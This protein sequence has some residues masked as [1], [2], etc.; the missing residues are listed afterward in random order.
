MMDWTTRDMLTATGGRLLCGAL[1]TTFS[2]IGIDSRQLDLDAFF[3]A[4][5]G[6]IHDGHKFAPD[7]VARGGRGVLVREGRVAKTA[8]ATWKKGGV[9]CIAV[10]DTTRALGDLAAYHR[11]R[12]PAR[13]AAL[14]GS[15]GKTTTRAMTAAIFNRKAATLATRGNLNNEIGLPLTLLQLKA[16]HAL[17]VVEMGM[18]HPGEIDRMGRMAVPDIGMIINVAPAH[19]E[20]LQTIEGVRRAKGE[21]LNHIQPDGRA[22]INADDEQCR[23]LI[24]TCPVETVLFGFGP[25]ARVRGRELVSGRRG[26]TFVLQLPSGDI[27]VKLQVPGK[28]MVA[29]A[30]AAAAAADCCEIALEDIKAGL[31]SVEAVDG[32]MQV[33]SLPWGI[34]L[35]NDC[36]NAN[37]AS[38]AAAI[39]T[40][41]RMKGA[42]RGAL[43][44][45]D[46]LELGPDAE[47][48]HRE[49]GRKAGQ[50]GL[51][52]LFI[53]G[54]FAQA[55]EEGAAE[56]G[57]DADRILVG[58]I[59]EISIALTQWLA[60]GDWVLVKGSRGM[61]MERVITALQ[62][63]AGGSKASA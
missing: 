18:N 44:L 29:N 51:D 5:E 9:V 43:V 62:E 20:G 50:A 32:R 36:Y 10:P 34:T 41:T 16:E 54:T 57:M 47:A 14:T 35:I 55:V 6:D 46:M 63:W 3:I 48:W 22:I 42:S 2:G 40:M 56:V 11:R 17:A 45:G 27:P 30:L 8:L 58:D 13:I 61:R 25:E 23:Q 33:V 38:T 52:R 39:E 7:V 59:G 53:H 37:P 49:T 28:F 26:W 15:N 4:I 12:M 19:L 24:A 60:P 1:E 31:E 21:L